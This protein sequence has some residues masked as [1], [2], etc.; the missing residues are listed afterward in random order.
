LIK[1]EKS[2]YVTF[3]KTGD[4]TP[5]RSALAELPRAVADAYGVLSWQ[6]YF[7]LIAHDWQRAKQFLERMNGGPDD[8]NFAFGKTPVPVGCYSTLLARLPE[9]QN[10]ANSSFAQ[11]R[12]QLNQKVQRSPGNAKLV[13]QLAVVDALLGYKENAIAEAK[14]AADMLPISRDALDGPNVAANVVAVC[15]WSAELDLAF[16]TLGPLTKTPNGLYYG[17]L[18]LN[19]Y[20]EPLRR[21]PR[22]EKL[23]AE[24]APKD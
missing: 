24:L 2:Y 5:A 6:L 10:D 7:A 14:H 21:D 20:L 9:E 16:E 17:D 3:L 1:F 18:K 23:L 13:S 19:P 11:T 15:A 4:A 22:F 12:E 8:V